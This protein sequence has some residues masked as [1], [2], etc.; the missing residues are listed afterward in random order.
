MDLVHKK[1]TRLAGVYIYNNWMH[2]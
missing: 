2:R 1:Q